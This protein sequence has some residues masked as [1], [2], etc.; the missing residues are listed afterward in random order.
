M[1]IMQASLRGLHILSTLHRKSAL[2]AENEMMPCRAP[3]ISVVIDEEENGPR[4]MLNHLS[5]MMVHGTH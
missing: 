3:D 4:V 5:K 1:A 2:W